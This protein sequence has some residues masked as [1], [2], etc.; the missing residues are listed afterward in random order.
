LP[1]AN[2]QPKVFQPKKLDE[3]FY[4]ILKT[5]HEKENFDLFIVIAYG[6]IIPEKIINLPKYGTI[7]LHYSLLP[8]YRGASPIESAILNNETETGITIQ[9]MKFELDA[10]DILFQEKAKVDENETTTELRN[11]LNKRALEIF[12][13]FLKTKLSHSHTSSQSSPNLGEGVEQKNEEATFCKKIKK[14]DLNINNILDNTSLNREEKLNQIFT[15][16][17]AYDKKIYFFTEKNLQ[18]IRIKIT[19]MKKENNEIKILK[20][21]PESKKEI[22]LK[23]FENSYDKIS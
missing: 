16:Y 7:N 23:D 20:L 22:N 15:K 18:K 19:E 11:K 5:E 8:K 3:E 17:K 12:P 21:L 4:N 1:S 14:E 6:K 9:Q 10:G 13:E 2:F